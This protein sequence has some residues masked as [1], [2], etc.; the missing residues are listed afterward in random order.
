MKLTLKN[1][2]RL[3]RAADALRDDGPSASSAAALAGARRAP[4]TAAVTT[5]STSSGSSSSTSAG[6]ASSSSSSSSSSADVRGFPVRH[7][8]VSD[9]SSSRRRRASASATE[10][11]M[12]AAENTA[13]EMA[14]NAGGPT[15]E[16]EVA[17]ARRRRAGR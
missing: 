12:E 2:F 9:F 7:L 1:F 4:S 15:G 11:T 16:D 6:S 3:P 13:K 8:V 14:H 17:G 10:A 5:A